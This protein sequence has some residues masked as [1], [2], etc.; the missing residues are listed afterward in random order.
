MEWNTL[1]PA[2]FASLQAT[3]NKIQDSEELC[4]IFHSSPIYSSLI[5]SGKN[6]SE[7]NSIETD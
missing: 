5:W 1:L 2:T 4:N 3:P 7:G 6:N